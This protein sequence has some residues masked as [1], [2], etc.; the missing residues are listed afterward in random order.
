MGAHSGRRKQTL[1]AI[2]LF[3]LLALYASSS[4]ALADDPATLKSLTLRA[5]LDGYVQVIHEL[6]V[7]ESSPS[8]NVILLGEPQG[9]LVVDEQ[10]LLLDFSLADFLVSV[11]SLGCSWMRTSYFTQDLTSKTGKY[12]TL[13]AS[14]PI[15]TTVVLPEEASIISLNAVPDLIES[16]GDQTTLVMPAGLVEISYVAERIFT[17]EPTGGI[18]SWLLFVAV[19]LL[20]ILIVAGAVWFLRRRIPKPPKETEAGSV[21]VEKLLDRE[22]D[23]RQEEVQVIRFLAEQNGSA[24]EAELYERLALPRTTTWRLLKRLE[25]ME[26]VEIRK[27][28]RQNI[29][30]VRKKYMKKQVKEAS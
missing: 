10:E 20:L 22:K 9:L 17:E 26:I 14:V 19:T 21:D 18:S 28:R 29:V 12:W 27:T 23:L 1:A 25:K 11:D 30:S 4:L 5:Y 13:R 8:V 2:L 7:D 6:D 16:S 15:N 24:F 3:S